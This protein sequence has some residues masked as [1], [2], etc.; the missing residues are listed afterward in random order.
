MIIFLN[1]I[2]CHQDAKYKIDIEKKLIHVK[3]PFQ[4]GIFWGWNQFLA[5]LSSLSLPIPHPNNIRVVK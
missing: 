3:W 5:F 2:K 4:G 1:L